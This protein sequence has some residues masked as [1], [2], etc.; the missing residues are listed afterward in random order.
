MGKTV[1]RIL[2][3]R[4]TFDSFVKL[5][6]YVGHRISFPE[7]ALVEANTS[8]AGI[9]FIQFLMAP[10]PLERMT[11]EQALKHPWILLDEDAQSDGEDVNDVQD[12]TTMVNVSFDWDEDIT[13]PA[14]NWTSDIETAYMKTLPQDPSKETN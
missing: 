13:Q 7:E 6:D 1:F 11:A 2:T 10:F 8:E 4:E 14:T 5:N 9:A 3:D 12:N